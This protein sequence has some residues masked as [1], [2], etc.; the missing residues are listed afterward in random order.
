[1]WLEGQARQGDE[2]DG[3]AGGSRGVGGQSGYFSE[4]SCLFP[5]LTPS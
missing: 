1:M 2:Q 3:S 4:D 5:H